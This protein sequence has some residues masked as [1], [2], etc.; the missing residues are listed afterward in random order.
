MALTAEER[1]I[2]VGLR[3]GDPGAADWLA[4]LDEASQ[5]RVVAALAQP[6]GPEPSGREA[7][8]AVQEAAPG[9][10]GLGEVRARPPKRSRLLGTLVVL[11]GLVV[12]AVGGYVLY[13]RLSGDDGSVVVDSSRREDRERSL[14]DVDDSAR[15]GELAADD[16]QQA[17]G[18]AKPAKSDGDQ[19]LTE[20]SAVKPAPEPMAEEEPMEEPEPMAE[21]EPMEE[22]E[23]VAEEEPMEEPVAEEEPVAD[24][25]TG[26][27]TSG[28][29]V[30]A[31]SRDG[32]T[33]IV[34][35][36]GTE[37]LQLPGSGFQYQ[38]QWSPDSTRILVQEVD[39][40]GWP[41]GASIYSVD[42]VDKTAD[43][44]SSYWGAF[45]D[46]DWSPDGSH[47]V[48][49]NFAEARLPDGL[50]VIDAGGTDIRQ[51]TDQGSS[52]VW[53]PD[54]SK[55]AYDLGFDSVGIFVVDA[56]GR[57]TTQI[58]DHGSSPVW[59]P[60]GSDILFTSSVQ[61]DRT[62]FLM[63][64]NGSEVR[65]LTNGGDPR[66]SP[67][68]A[69]VAF[70]RF[71]DRDFKVFVMDSDGTDIRQLT[72]SDQS[73]RG[74]AWSP[75]PIMPASA[76]TA[77]ASTETSDALGGLQSATSAS[78]VIVLGSQHTCALQVDDR[79]A[80]WGNNRSGQVD[81]PGGQFITL[82]A[83]PWHSCGLKIDGTIACW[84]SN[85][86]G[87]ANAPAGQFAAVAAGA[88][89]TCGLRTDRTVSCW[90]D[91]S[92]GQ[93]HTPAGEFSAVTTA[94]FHSCALRVD[95]TVSCWGDDGLGQAS[96]PFGEFTAVTTGSLH[97]C[98]LT[99]DQTVT[100][101][102]ANEGL[103][104]Y[105][106]QADAPAGQFTAV[107]AGEDHTCGLRIDR[108]VSCWGDNRRGQ[109]SA[110]SGE[111]TSVSTAYY[112]SCGLRSDETVACWGY[113]R[114]GQTSAPPGMFAAVVAGYYH[115]CGLK[116]DGAIS[117]WGANSDG[118]ATAPAGRFSSG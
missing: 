118:R 67:D 21:E 7:G 27:T 64:A 71:V 66:W 58:A 114:E 77:G 1:E 100:C 69:K 88:N 32:V 96:A 84:G 103:A 24:I 49:S 2:L 90:G 36:D 55:V 11:A 25:A 18:E 105:T 4:S 29:Y 112:H 40:E 57:N 3:A 54:G 6:E 70:T 37:L 30:I 14:D 48:F 35:P 17:P 63:S 20:S 110:P 87:E 62:I 91:N 74:P 10:E 23:P 89:H 109:A 13:D 73:D 38:P 93:L 86:S 65:Q 44:F 82:T 111:F 85:R 113:N 50:F 61:G 53:S 101:W 28:V 22:P 117:C 5:Q 116:P 79:I 60:D 52:P 97:S 46:H 34:D 99:A 56:D 80:C 15:S 108:T 42:L 68:G 41:R 102:G 16:Q 33:T 75:V 92:R 115:S 98:G 59:S 104:G 76:E 78:A 8:P 107:A 47:V 31:L 39:G 43:S 81:A 26:P 72:D 95:R 19:G 106:G 9:G 45:L 12:V 83:G 94:Y 51:L